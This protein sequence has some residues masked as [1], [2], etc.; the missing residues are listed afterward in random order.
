VSGLFASTYPDFTVFDGE[1]L[2]DGE[3]VSGNYGLWVTNGT[4][5]G[6][7]ELT[8]IS[9]ASTA[10]GL[11]PLDFTVLNGEVLFNGT[12]ANNGHWTMGDQRT[13]GRYQ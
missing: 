11:F 8:G 4:A 6:T 12:Q 5:T 9:G 2:F 3:D 1:V 7:F 13:G 10:S